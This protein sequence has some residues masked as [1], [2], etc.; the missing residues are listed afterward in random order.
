[1]QLGRLRGFRA[2][3]SE[4]RDKGNGVGM[5]LSLESGQNAGRFGRVGV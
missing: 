3:N 1:M 2:G 4:V 5:E